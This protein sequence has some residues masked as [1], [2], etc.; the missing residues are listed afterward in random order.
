M[1]KKTTTKKPD[2]KVFTDK[3]LV[4]ELE[5]R[6]YHIV[7]LKTHGIYDTYELGPM[8]IENQEIQDYVDRYFEDVDDDYVKG[9]CSDKYRKRFKEEVRENIRDWV[10][11]FLGGFPGVDDLSHDME[12]KFSELRSELDEEENNDE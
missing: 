7:N 6:N 2:I 8:I 4:K 12:C 5:K 1:K 9:Y 3:Q 10:E 11:D